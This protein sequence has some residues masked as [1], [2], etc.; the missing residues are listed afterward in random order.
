MPDLFAGDAVSDAEQEAGL[1][2]TAWRALH[3]TPDIDRIIHT[4]IAYMHSELE[5]RRLEAW[6]TALEGNMFLGS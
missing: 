2:L 4:T 5:L 3:P 1:N 6:G